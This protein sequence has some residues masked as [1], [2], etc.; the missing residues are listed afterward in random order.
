MLKGLFQKTA[1]LTLALS[2]L[3]F[4]SMHSY[5]DDEYSESEAQM[6]QDVSDA[7]FEQTIAAFQ[8]APQSAA[9]FDHSYGYAVFPTIGKVGFVIGGAYGKGRVYEQGRFSGNVE[10][11]QATIGFQLGGQAF[12]QIIFFQDQRAYDEFTSGNFEFGAQ[13][14]AIVITAGAN[15]EASTKGTSASANAGNK[16]VKADGQYYKGMAVFSLAKGGLMYEATLGGQKFNFYP[17]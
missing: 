9:F 11:T 1:I 2:S 8:K 16:Y 15:A 12:S 13:A 17:N 7:E 6:T 14:S 5:A 10:M 3:A 4:F